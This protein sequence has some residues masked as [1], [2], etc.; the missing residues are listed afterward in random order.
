MR[1]AL[2]PEV[3]S[4]FVPGSIE[5]SWLQHM[6]PRAHLPHW[7]GARAGGGTARG[8]GGWGE[9]LCLGCAAGMAIGRGPRL[10]AGGCE[11]R[12]A[13][14]PVFPWLGRRGTGHPCLLVPGPVLLVCGFQAGRTVP[15]RSLALH[16]CAGKALPGAPRGFACAYSDG[17]IRVRPPRGSR[18]GERGG[19]AACPLH[20][21]AGLSLAAAGSGALVLPSGMESWRM[22]PPVQG[23][24]LHPRLLSRD[25]LFTRTGVPLS[26]VGAMRQHPLGERGWEPPPAHST[27]WGQA[28][29]FPPLPRPETL[30]RLALAV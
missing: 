23:P 16:P 2:Q 12:G 6:R 9:P 5:S 27:G 21:R 15:A 26:G 17:S 24:A 22:Q 7:A 28:A 20:P 13:G 4:V 19:H 18:V 25:L 14:M 3:G 10:L 29:P 8:W 30:P 1:R 11:H